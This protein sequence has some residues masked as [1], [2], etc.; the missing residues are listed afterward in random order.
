MARRPAWPRRTAS[1]ARAGMVAGV[2]VLAAAPSGGAVTMPCAG[3]AYAVV[4]PALLSEWIGADAIRLG[5]DTA[6]IR[7]GCEE[8]PVRV[9]A[10]PTEEHV[11]RAMFTHCAIAAEKVSLWLRV[12]DDCTRLDGRI[13][14]LPERFI[15]VFE[16]RPVSEESAAWPRPCA[17]EPPPQGDACQDPA[18]IDCS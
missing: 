14:L 15:R 17:C 10:T 9:D 16:A 1:L 3:R 6:A 11:M 7:S 18:T 4:G 8:A 12:R 5:P 2:A 13:G